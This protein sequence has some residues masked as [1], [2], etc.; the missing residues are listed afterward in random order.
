M[1]EN[2]SELSVYAITKPLLDL[3]SLKISIFEIPL[4]QFFPEI[5]LATSILVL[6]M[7]ASLLSTTY[8]LGNPL[9]TKSLSKLC[10]LIIALTFFLI[11]SE[12]RSDE[13]LF[14]HSLYAFLA[15]NN[16]FIF[17]SLS[18][19]AKQIVLLGVFFSLLISETIVLRHKINAFEYLILLLCA[20]LGLL[21]LTSAY[22]LISLY[23][24]IEV[25]SLCLYV[26]AASKKNS[27]FSLEAGLKY[28]ILGSFSSALFLFGAS[29]LY[30]CV[31]TTNFYNFSLFFSGL[32]LN[33]FPLEVSV[34]HA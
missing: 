13:L 19:G 29:L 28:F 30:G 27:S 3:I 33:S 31:G 20:T 7:H 15:Y 4:I 1:S 12:I 9:L 14:N 5:F 17:D 18:Q 10:L 23:L 26:L 34:E 2:L 24:A 16:T 8:K 22:D 11:S 25:Q 21:F 32:D 6:I